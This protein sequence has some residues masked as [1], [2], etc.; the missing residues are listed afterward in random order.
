MRFFK[1]LIALLLTLQIS[2][3]LFGYDVTGIWSWNIS[4]AAAVG[5]S[6]SNA[7][8]QFQQIDNQI[9]GYA[10][11]NSQIEGN[12]TGIVEGS[13]ITIQ[14]KTAGDVTTG[15]TGTISSDGN[16]IQL[17]SSDTKLVVTMFRTS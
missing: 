7:L 11:N 1:Y 9:I 14:I 8:I 10:Y 13:K 4:G 17:K 6:S 15:Y 5:V 3:G 2:C 16:S 12:I